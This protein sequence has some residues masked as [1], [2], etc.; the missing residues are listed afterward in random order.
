MR[1]EIKQIVLYDISNN[2][3]QNLG[4]YQPNQM[5]VL[6]GR[7]IISVLK[8]EITLNPIASLIPTI[9][10]PSETTIVQKNIDTEEATSKDGGFTV[11]LLD[12]QKRKLN[13]DSEELKS[14]IG[15]IPYGSMYSVT[16]EDPKLT[17]ITVTL[18][19]GIGSDSRLAV[20]GY[21]GQAWDYLGG[22]I[23]GNKRIVK[24]DYTKYK[25]FI[26]ARPKG[27]FSDIYGNWANDS[28]DILYAHQ[29]ITGYEDGRFA[30]DRTVTRAELS[31]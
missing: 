25:K 31:P 12:H 29:K 6:D 16:I 26:L 30:P 20:Y 17:D 9:N 14:L 7:N 3:E 15:L 5:V 18:R 23:F 11:S 28:I 4:S 8:N 27:Q 10:E 2:Q 19:L 1:P 13:V 24:V 21:N 22:G